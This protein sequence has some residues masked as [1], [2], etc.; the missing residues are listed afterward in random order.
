M[1][2][3]LSNHLLYYSA[4]SAL[5]SLALESAIGRQWYQLYENNQK[6]QAFAIIKNSEVIWQTENWNLV[7]DAEDL[8]KAQDSAGSKV[9]AGGNKYKRVTGTENSYVATADK[10]G[11]HLLMARIDRNSWAVARAEA[12]SVPELALVDLMR[13]A[14]ILKSSV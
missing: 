4:P 10:E 3:S 8:L 6:L 1:V 7:D 2:E 13:T 14:I 5:E 12:S 11:G 9:S